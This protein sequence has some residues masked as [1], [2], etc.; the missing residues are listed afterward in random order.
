MTSMLF[1]TIRHCPSQPHGAIPEIT[2]LGSAYLPSGRYSKS[3][4]YPFGP[5]T[6]MALFVSDHLGEQGMPRTVTWQ[7][8]LGNGTP[9]GF[10]LWLSISAI[11]SGTVARTVGSPPSGA[12]SARISS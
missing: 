8:Y 1:A 6:S 4:P 12:C 9:A 3:Y 10:P 11:R 2:L 7:L 5:P